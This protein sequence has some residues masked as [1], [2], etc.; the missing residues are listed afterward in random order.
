ML[1]RPRPRPR[2]P[3]H[4]ALSSNP[5]GFDAFP[6]GIDQHPVPEANDRIPVTSGQELQPNQE[7]TARERI[8]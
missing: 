5:G 4:Q 6:R 1:T 8:N 2:S 7:Q 3:A